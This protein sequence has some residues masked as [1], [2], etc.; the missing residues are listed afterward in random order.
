MP[1]PTLSWLPGLG[2]WAYAAIWVGFA[3][4]ALGAAWQFSGFIQQLS[5]Q[6]KQPKLPAQVLRAAQVCIGV[7]LPLY[8]VLL[9]VRSP[10]LWVAPAL[11]ASG[12]FLLVSAWLTRFR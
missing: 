8:L 1:D 6:G 2:A 9:G 4:L 7:S 3:L 11:T 5:L 10:V 12:A